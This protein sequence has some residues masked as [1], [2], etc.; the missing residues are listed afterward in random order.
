MKNIKPKACSNCGYYHEGVSCERAKQGM[1]DF[2][3]MIIA[4]GIDQ[5]PKK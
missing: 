1:K 4:S 2:V 3:T 5:A